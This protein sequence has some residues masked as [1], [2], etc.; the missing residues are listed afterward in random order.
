MLD[1]VLTPPSASVLFYVTINVTVAPHGIVACQLPL[2]LGSL[3]DN[4]SD[5]TL[6]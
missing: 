6:A 2:T 4:L 3:D 5:H 1:T